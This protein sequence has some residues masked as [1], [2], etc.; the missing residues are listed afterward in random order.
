MPDIA[1]CQ[2]KTCPSRF[3]CYRYMAV[4]NDRW[5]S[6]MSFKVKKNS[7]KCDSFID[8]TLMD[9]KRLEEQHAKLGTMPD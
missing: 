6:Y 2:N 1:M 4:P 7:N 5:Q 9:R 8:L 3:K